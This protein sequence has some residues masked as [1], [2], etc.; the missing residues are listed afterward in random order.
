M[1]SATPRYKLQEVP[2][3][4]EVEVDPD[5]MDSDDMIVGKGDGGIRKVL[6]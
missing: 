2:D 6:S 5:E 3:D 4:S 1:C